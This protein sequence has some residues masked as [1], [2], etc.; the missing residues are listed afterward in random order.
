MKNTIYSFAGKSRSRDVRS[1]RKKRKNF[2]DWEDE[3]PDVKEED[4]DFLDDKII[5]RKGT[6][7]LGFEN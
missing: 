3:I 5:H 4:E 7:K 2:E 1:K 6:E